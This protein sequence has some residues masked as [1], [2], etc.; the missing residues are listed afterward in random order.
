MLFQG[1]INLIEIT[2]S[3]VKNNFLKRLVDIVFAIGGLAV[4]SPLF[5]I[6]AIWIKLD[7]DGSI[8]YRGRR[9]GRYC[10]PFYQIKFRTMVSDAERLGGSRTSNIDSRITRAGKILRQYK[11]DELPQLLNVVIGEMSLVGPR[12]DVEEYVTLYTESEKGIMSLRP[13][14]T[15]WATLWYRDEGEALAKFADPDLAYIQYFHR[16]KVKLQLDYLYNHSIVT[17]ICI[18]MLTLIAIFRRYWL[19]QMLANRLMQIGEPTT[20]ATNARIPCES[21]DENLL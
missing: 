14:L 21:T 2:T 10:R 5:A 15:D 20:L 13:G 16:T 6:I 4:F 18:I 8:F 1:D 17:D 3:C 9:I 11:L 19:P 7:S 12:P